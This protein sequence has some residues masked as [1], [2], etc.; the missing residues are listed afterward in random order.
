M[1]KRLSSELEPALVHFLLELSLATCLS[2]SKFRAWE[3]VNRAE[4]MRQF[5]LSDEPAP[6]ECGIELTYNIY[7]RL[8]YVAARVPA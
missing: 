5:V 3:R 2:E 4:L 7:T 1:N 6:D 8:Q